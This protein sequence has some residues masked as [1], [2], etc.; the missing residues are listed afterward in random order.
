MV[1]GAL[2]PLNFRLLIKIRFLSDAVCLHASPII[3]CVIVDTV[4]DTEGVM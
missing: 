3:L 1:G 4:N 2:A